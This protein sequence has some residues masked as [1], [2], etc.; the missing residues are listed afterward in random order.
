VETNS[1]S[2]LDEP[3]FTSA[4]ALASEDLKDIAR[5]ESHRMAPGNSFYS[6]TIKN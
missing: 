5:C 1:H 6:F 2:A 4:I 3:Y